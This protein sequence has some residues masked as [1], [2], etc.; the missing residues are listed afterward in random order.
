MNL[1]SE[2]ITVSSYKTHFLRKHSRVGHYNVPNASI[3][4]YSNLLKS[5]RDKKEYSYEE[6]YAKFWPFVLCN[7]NNYL[8]ELF[9][10]VS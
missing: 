6:E 4:V 10:A 2:V 7:E 5:G 8:L 9:R 1:S 3:S